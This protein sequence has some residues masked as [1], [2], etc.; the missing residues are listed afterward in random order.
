MA[1]I[2][3][4]DLFGGK[5]NTLRGEQRLY[6]I[7]Q[8]MSLRS[9]PYLLYHIN[10]PPRRFDIYIPYS[11]HIPMCNNVSKYSKRSGLHR[12]PALL[13]SANRGDDFP[14]PASDG[15]GL[16]TLPYL[17]LLLDHFPATSNIFLAFLEHGVILLSAPKIP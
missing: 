17:T 6:I 2:R 1:D 7:G 10:L 4:A 8:E 14:S 9:I 11:I 3:Q 16:I 13:T 12:K 15:T 5:F